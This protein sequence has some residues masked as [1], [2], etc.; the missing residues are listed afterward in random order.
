MTSSYTAGS[1][2][3][4][5]LISETAPIDKKLEWFKGYFRPHFE[6]VILDPIHQLVHSN[7]ALIGFILMACTIDYLAGYLYGGDTTGQVKTTYKTFIEKYLKKYGYNPDELYDSLRNGFVHNFTI[8]TYKYELTQQ[9]ENYH[10][11]DNG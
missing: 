10:L 1:A 5:P 9:Q 2:T 4:H 6:K 8:K 11:D 7:N 3:P